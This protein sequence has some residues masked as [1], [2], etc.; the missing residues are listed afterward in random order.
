[1]E[2]ESI[3]EL[4]HHVVTIREQADGYGGTP[5]CKN[6]NRHF[7]SGADLIVLPDTKD[8]GERAYGVRDV[9]GPVTETCHCGSQARS[10]HVSGDPTVF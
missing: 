3:P 7:A 2:S 4:S 10:K 5:V 1:M 9:V 6:P 8:G